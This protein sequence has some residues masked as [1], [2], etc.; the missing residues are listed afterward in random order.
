MT[1]E[2]DCTPTWGFFAFLD[3]ENECVLIDQ[4]QIHERGGCTITMKLSYSEARKLH[5][6]LQSNLM[7]LE[8]ESGSPAG[9]LM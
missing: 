1:K 2:L 7:N 8:T 6:W 5:E 3:E 4:E 9:T